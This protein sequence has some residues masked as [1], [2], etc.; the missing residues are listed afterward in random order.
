MKKEL[1]KPLASRGLVTDK[2][3]LGVRTWTCTC[4][5]PT[6]PTAPSASRSTRIIRRQGGY[7]RR[8]RRE[9]RHCI[10]ATDSA[11]GKMQRRFSLRMSYWYRGEKPH[12]RVSFADTRTSRL[13]GDVYGIVFATGLRSGQ[14]TL[15]EMQCHQSFLACQV[16]CLK[17][18]CIG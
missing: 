7:V 12:V 16:L 6:A 10:E 18:V 2:G 13:R 17:S 5:T 8:K 11:K 14:T 9:T 4:S 15:S 3:N 1:Y